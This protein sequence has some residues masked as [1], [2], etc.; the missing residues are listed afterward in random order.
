MLK[1]FNYSVVLILLFSVSLFAQDLSD[2]TYQMPAKVLADLADAPLTP[3]VDVDPTKTWLLILE[4]P[5]LP[6]ISELAQPEFRIAGLRI[7]PKNNGPSRGRYYSAMKLKKLS[8]GDELEITGLPEDA[9]I[10]NVQWSPDG[11]HVAFLVVE[12]NGQS[13]WVAQVSSK[14]ASRLGSLEV[15]PVI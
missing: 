6:S 4:S 10:R 8:G 1:F 12:E 9:R 2:K 5:S 3:S 15:P 14:K 7:N 11:K 13:L